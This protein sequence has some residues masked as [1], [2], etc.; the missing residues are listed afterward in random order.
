MVSCATNMNLLMFM[1]KTRSNYCSPFFFTLLQENVIDCVGNCE[2][3]ANWQGFRKLDCGF[4]ALIYLANRGLLGY[5]INP[6]TA[7]YVIKN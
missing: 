2:L 1:V 6:F 7:S 3:G 4:F 5:F